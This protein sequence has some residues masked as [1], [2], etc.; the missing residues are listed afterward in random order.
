[1]LEGIDRALEEAALSLGA[2]P[3]A[4]FRRVVWPLALPGIAAGSVLTFILTMNA[5]ASPVLLGGPKFMMMAPLVYRQFELS[6]WPFGAAASFVLMTTTLVLAVV[7]NHL[8][9]RRYQ[10]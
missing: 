9:Q 10:R 2:D 7:S 4:M 3:W 5:Y 8:M 1:V 6:N